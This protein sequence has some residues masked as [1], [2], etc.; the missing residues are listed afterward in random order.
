[1]AQPIDLPC[2]SANLELLLEAA[3][4]EALAA[5]EVQAKLSGLFNAGAKIVVAGR[6]KHRRQNYLPQRYPPLFHLSLHNVEIYLAGLREFEGFTFFVA[7]V[8]PAK[9]HRRGVRIYPRI[10]YKDV[11]LIWRSATHYIRTDDEHWVGKGAIKPV[12]EDGV[13]VWYSAEETSDLPLEMQPAL[14]AASR[15]SPR[16]L[17]DAEALGLVLRNAPSDRVEPYRDF[18]APREAAAHK[19]DWLVNAGHP[20]AWFEDGRKPESLKF[21]DGFEPDFRTGY[22]DASLSKSAFY[23]GDVIK[24]RFLS[25]NR[26]VHYLFVKTPGVSWLIP[27]Q[28]VLE[29]LTTFAVRPVDAEVDER[30]CL[31]GFEYH[32]LDETTDPPSW[33]TQIPAGFAGSPHP[34][35]D[36]RAST[37]PWN[38]R[39]PVL[40]AFQAWWSAKPRYINEN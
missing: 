17:A 6:A 18:L 25:T 38:D 32:F 2:S 14:D 31:P 9:G 26:Q 3:E 10:F 28:S 4:L 11:S 24:A 7:Y 16:S 23:G 37:K 12:L 27:P 1:M 5:D 19:A 34:V 8:V 36:D 39:L 22:I 15:R 35:D 29:E 13:E 21:A 20:I 30:L 33:H 40:S